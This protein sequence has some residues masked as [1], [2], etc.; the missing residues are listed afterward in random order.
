[1][2]PRVRRYAVLIGAT[3]WAVSLANCARPGP[4]GFNGHNKGEDFVH[5]Y[6]LGQVAADHA[7]GELYDPGAQQRR[8]VDTIKGAV[9]VWCV[10]AYGPQVA[11]LMRPF[12]RLPYL[13][14]LALW[15]SSSVLAVV[16]SLCA[17][18]TVLPSV[19]AL[20]REP[21]RFLR[22]LRANPEQH[23]ASLLTDHGDAA[24]VSKDEAGAMRQ[25]RR[26]KA[27]GAL[28]IG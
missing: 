18:A 7:A 4:I 17:L 1:M 5:F 28:L 20:G 10:P 13:A 16:L 23:F 19:K 2:P 8:L 6:I 27:E 26:M 25:L 14:S 3:L 21:D 9:P 12:A 15:V 22:L 11:L 24:A